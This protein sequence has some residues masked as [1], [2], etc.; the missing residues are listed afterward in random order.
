MANGESP[1][2]K[3]LNDTRLASYTPISKTT[4]QLKTTTVS[5]NPHGD[6]SRCRGSIFNEMK[7]VILLPTLQ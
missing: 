2:K 3:A 1:N 5:I 4:S 6:K 7:K